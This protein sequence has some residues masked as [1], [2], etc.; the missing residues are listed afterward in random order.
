MICDYVVIYNYMFRYLCV[1]H[2]FLSWNRIDA[3]HPD[4]FRDQDNLVEIYLAGN[5]LV[6]VNPKIFSVHNVKHLQV[7]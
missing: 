1:F 2:R 6:I 5:R 7:L 4:T 3:L